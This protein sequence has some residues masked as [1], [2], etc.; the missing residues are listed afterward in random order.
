MIRPPPRSTRTDT[1]FPYT[2]LFR[3]I[4]RQAMFED[5]IFDTGKTERPSD[6]EALHLQVAGDQFHRRDPAAPQTVDECAAIGEGGG[7][8]PQAKPGGISEI[9]DVRRAGCRHGQS[10]GARQQVLQAQSGSAACR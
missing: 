2:T 3:S 8:T 7:R 4:V 10:A 6:I 5:V 1:L 9:V